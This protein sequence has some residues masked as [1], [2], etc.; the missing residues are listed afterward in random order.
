METKGCFFLQFDV[1]KNV[2]DISFRLIINMFTLT[3]RGSTLDVRIWRLEDRLKTSESDV[4]DFRR[5]N[6]TSTDVRFWRLKSI[7]A[8]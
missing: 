8:L 7:P 4:Y 6:L 5:Q 1:I 3:V 2:S